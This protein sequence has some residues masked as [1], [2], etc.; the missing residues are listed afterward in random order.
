MLAGHLL[1]RNNTRGSESGH[2]PALDELGERIKL[3]EDA[4]RGIVEQ[5]VRGLELCGALDGCGISG[6]D[7]EHAQC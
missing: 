1:C 6:G 3:E 7:S 2:L 4:L 5:V